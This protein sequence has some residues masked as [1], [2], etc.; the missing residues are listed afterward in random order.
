MKIKIS[1]KKFVD[2]TSNASFKKITEMQLTLVYPATSLFAEKK[3]AISVFIRDIALSVQF[4]FVISLQ[5]RLRN[6][7][8]NKKSCRRF[9]CSRYKQSNER[10]FIF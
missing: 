1:H 6:K 3:I 2:E 4:S 7:D 9:S 8:I 10:D 5:Q